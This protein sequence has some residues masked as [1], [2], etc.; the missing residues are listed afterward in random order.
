M[1]GEIQFVM[2]NG[3]INERPIPLV[4]FVGENDARQIKVVTFDDMSTVSVT[5]LVIGDI[6]A[7]IFE[8]EQKTIPV[9]DRLSGAY[10]DRTQTTLSIY[11]NE[12]MLGD[13]GLKF[14]QLVMYNETGE[15]V[16]KTNQ[17]IV[18][19]GDSNTPV[20]YAPETKTVKT[21]ETYVKEVT[22]EAIKL[23]FGL[24]EEVTSSSDFVNKKALYVYKGNEEDY[25]N[26]YWYYY[27]DTQKR[28]V[29]GGPYKNP[30]DEVLRLLAQKQDALTFD[31]TPTEDSQNPVTSDGVF[32]ALAGHQITMDEFPINGSTN[33][34]TS[35]GLYRKFGEVDAQHQSLSTRVGRIQ[36]EQT[37]LVNGVQQ[38]TA[39]ISQNTANI[40]S[41]G[42]TIAE[43]QTS[44]SENADAIEEVRGIANSASNKAD[45]V[46]DRLDNI[47]VESGTS[48]A[49]TIAARTNTNTG[50]TYTTLG[51]RLDE[52]NSEI[53]EDLSDI[54]GNGVNLFDKNNPAYTTDYISG[55]VADGYTITAGFVPRP[56]ALI[57]VPCKPFTQYT[58][59]KG[60]SNQFRVGYV[61]DNV[62]VGAVVY[63]FHNE[64][65]TSTKYTML[66]GEGATYIVAWVGQNMQE[67]AFLELAETI[68]IEEN[69]IS[70]PLTTHITGHDEIARRANNKDISILFVGNSV[71]EDAVAYLPYLLKS[72]CPE[73]NFKIYLWYRGGR[74]LAEQYEGFQNDVVADR[75]SVAENTRRWTI[76]SNSMTMANVL[77]S[78]TFNVVCMM[79]YYNRLNTADNA[80]ADWNNCA[81]YIRTNYKGGNAL[82]F[83]EFIH[84][85]S[86]SAIEDKFNLALTGCKK[87]LKETNCQ[88]LLAGGIAIY[89]AFSTALDSLGDSGHLSVDG[90][91]AQE[92]LPCLIQ[93]Y[94]I[95]LWI[96]G[97]LGINKSIYGSSTTITTTVYNSI[98]TPGENLGTGVI[99]G[100]TK[101][102]VLAQE[103]AIVAYK[104][105]QSI[106]N[107]IDYLGE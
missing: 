38:N 4:G 6:E 91:H 27:D 15:I 29:P 22:E 64:P 98:N 28:W 53:K 68:Q 24:Q 88:G 42:A 81:N 93:T 40:S 69:S 35:D 78:Y 86:R 44:I 95:L 18:R 46:D 74:T 90:A 85:P 51:Q 101:L 16:K 7:G 94:T 56:N 19:V 43:H 5:E 58:I 11:L 55:S 34:V 8:A 50:I 20:Y 83:V 23:A 26:G 39:N 57:Y 102:N 100:T 65:A 10:V 97:E 3:F 59:T 80:T 73:L 84:A 104:T 99:T 31:S 45:A 70:T 41:Q 63:G 103:I 106:I 17:F 105:A 21:L 13:A 12:E 67:S 52:E 92:G 1:L 47:I 36:E 30:T 89:K 82:K 66:T 32:R 60:V 33:P 75:V 107:Q 79:D 72:F 77:D 96:L 49:E 14:L 71:L 54:S 48:D 25:Q 87:V 62:E 76:N 61:K 2:V 37:E 9:F